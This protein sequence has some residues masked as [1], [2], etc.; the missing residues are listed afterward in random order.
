MPALKITFFQAGCIM[1][2]YEDKLVTGFALE[3]Y[4][5]QIFMVSN[6]RY[7]DLPC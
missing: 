7:F 6:E 3:A 1:S 2:F 5:R 4:R